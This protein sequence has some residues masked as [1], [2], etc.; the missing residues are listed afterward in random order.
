MFFLTKI[1]HISSKELYE[2][3]FNVCREISILHDGKDKTYFEIRFQSKICDVWF[4]IP[5]FQGKGLKTT[6]NVHN[7]YYDYPKWF[8]VLKMN[9]FN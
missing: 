5:F 8:F 7:L 6:L 9:L 3:I 4:A 2:D 1:F